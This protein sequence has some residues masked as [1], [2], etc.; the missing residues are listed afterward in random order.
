MPDVRRRHDSQIL[1]PAAAGFANQKNADQRQHLDCRSKSGISLHCLSRVEVTS[2]SRVLFPAHDGL[3]ERQVRALAPRT[4]M[5]P[6]KVSQTLMH[7]GRAEDVPGYTVAKERPAGRPS[8]TRQR[9]N[10]NNIVGGFSYRIPCLQGT[11]LGPVKA[12]L[13]AL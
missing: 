7:H 4:C 11:W 12:C 9:G 5:G 3:D 2:M 1:G 8:L 10:R 6:L 13:F